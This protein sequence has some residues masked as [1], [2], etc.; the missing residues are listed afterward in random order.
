VRTVEIFVL[1]GLVGPTQDG[2]GASAIIVRPAASF[3][4]EVNVAVGFDLVLG[5]RR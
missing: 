4:D 5:Q 2:F 3:D 1:N